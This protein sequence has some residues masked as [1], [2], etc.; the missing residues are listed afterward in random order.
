MEKEEEI[1]KAGNSMLRVG[2]MEF[3]QSPETI[4]EKCLQFLNGKI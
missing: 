1:K 4:I 2:E 3:R